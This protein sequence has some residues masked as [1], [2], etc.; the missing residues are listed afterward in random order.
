[1]SNK[2]SGNKTASPVVGMVGGGQLAR[3]THQAAID[4]GIEL[5]VLARSV[6]EPAVMAGAKVL[7]GN[8]DDLFALERL[9]EES[10]VLT[11]DHELV[12]ATALQALAERGYRIRP[13]G[14]ALLAA[15]D[16]LWARS[17]FAEWGLP[18][19]EFTDLAPDPEAKLR[20]FGGRVGWPV[21]VKTRMGGYDGR[22]VQ[23]AENL[24]EA[25]PFIARASGRPLMAE[26]F[27]P[28]TREV[29]L[30]GVRSPSGA[31]ASYP[32]VE[33]RQTDGICR[34]LVMPAPVSRTV[35]ARA[36]EIARTIAE[37]LQAT[38]IM[39][40][41]LFVTAEDRLVVNEIALRP[42][43]SGHATIE[44][45][46]TSQF[47]NHLRAVLDWPLGDT[48]L[49]RPASAMVNILGDRA[50]SDPR[51]RLSHALEV[52][53]ARVHLYGKAPAPGRKLGHVT[54]FGESGEEALAT[55]RRC[56][57]IL[58]GSA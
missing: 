18:V 14:E 36:E 45:A 5:L 34:E 52:L 32:L 49:T 23:V 37:A 57:L 25:R 11:L 29:A 55:A 7:L 44:G 42:H 56:A 58:N 33:T 26:A 54:A 6:E 28:M 1:M 43:N 20:R 39:A 4:L 16:K 46:V 30:V 47:E 53:G 22:G 15:Q 2:G 31:W 10:D 50:R 27:V 12:P 51:T 35:A 9:A 17:R 40:T 19:P 38:G 48:S 24:E 3:M 13:R 21:V 8:P 41:E